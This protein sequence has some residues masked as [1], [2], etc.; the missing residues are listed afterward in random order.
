M[1]STFRIEINRCL[2]YKGIREYGI[3]V[4]KSDINSCSYF[5]QYSHTVHTIAECPIPGHILNL[6]R[7]FGPH[8]KASENTSKRV[9]SHIDVKKLY[10]LMLI[11]T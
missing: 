7:S 1:L 2:D 6:F 5:L 3:C 10:A 11:N 8:Q 9:G 4:G